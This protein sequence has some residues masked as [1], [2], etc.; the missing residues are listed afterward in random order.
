MNENTIQIPLSR[1]HLSIHNVRR[2]TP[3]RIDELAALI[4]SQGLLQNLVVVESKQPKGKGAAGYGVIAGGRRLRALQLLAERG[5]IP[6]DFSVPCKLVTEEAAERSSLAENSGRET[7]HPADEFE[8]FMRLHQDGSSI[9]DIAAAFGVTPL[10][11]QRRLKLATVSP[12]L[13]G[14]YRAGQ[15]QLDQVMALALTDDHALQVSAW[16][17]VRKQYM[18]ADANLLRAY[19]MRGMLSTKANAVANFVGIDD[20]EAAGGTVVRDLFGGPND[21]YLQDEELLKKLFDQKLQKAADQVNAEGWSWVTVQP[22]TSYLSHWG[23]RRSEPKQMP[24]SDEDQERIAQLEQQIEALEADQERFE[25]AGDYQQSDLADEQS[26]ALQAELEQIKENSKQ[27]TARQKAGAGVLMGVNSNGKLEIYRGLIKQQDSK[28]NSTKDKPPVAKPAHS[29]ALIRR[30]TA[31]RTA[32]MAAHMLE[33]PRLA[34]DML[35]TS[36]AESVLYEQ[37]TYYSALSELHI[38]ADS[39]LPM[40]QRQVDDL[41]FSKAW[42]LYDQRRAELRKSM[43]AKTDGLFQWMME[44]PLQD[45]MEILC[46]C[47]ASTLNTVTGDESSRPLAEVAT[48]L[49][50]AVEDWWQPTA[51]GYFKHVRKNEVLKIIKDSGGQELLPQ[52]EKLKKG[53]LDQQAEEIMAD[54]GWLPGVLKPTPAKKKVSPKRGTAS[55]VAA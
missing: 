21:G 25:D 4:K 10:V 32:A 41:E 11:V 49:G 40:L 3:Q 34:L 52:L 14:A 1:L 7:M 33:A 43:P 12:R 42:S 5:E 20:Y 30:L 2:T 6:T 36:L 15:M 16:E 35:C 54:T 19:I 51:S 17:D 38:R 31:H 27:Y 37:P 29:E 44:Q 13:I 45:V 8:A 53:Q 50:L 23:Y 18:R 48:A 46:F 26:E 55:E 24:L 39:Q 22:G 47:V 9:E 28:A